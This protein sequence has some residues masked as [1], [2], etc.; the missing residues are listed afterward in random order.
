MQR[1]HAADLDHVCSRSADVGP[2]A[3][4]EVGH[5]Y[6]MGLFCHVLHD[7]KPVSH[8]R[9]HHH[10]DGGSYADHVKIQMGSPHMLGLGHDLA[11]LDIH[12]RAQC[13]K[14]L[15]MLVDRSA[16][17]IASP[18][19]RYLRLAVLSKQGAKQIIRCPDLLYII[20][21]NVKVSNRTPVDLHSMPV[22]PL[23]R[24]PDA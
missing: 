4:E 22:K 9:R 19:K 14:S 17:D 7:R 13:A 10:V 12:V 20:I 23:H 18:R 24:C 3:V 16:S 15:Q 6:D 21:L 8:C 11:V 1:L 5:V 2:H